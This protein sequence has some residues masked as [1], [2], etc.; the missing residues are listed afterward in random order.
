[1][2]TATAGKR[3][4]AL[5]C[6]AAVFLAVAAAC[7]KRPPRR[8]GGHIGGTLLRSYTGAQNMYRRTDWDGDG[9]LE[10]AFPFTRLN[11]EVTDGQPIRIIDDAFANASRDNSPAGTPVPRAGCV[12]VDLTGDA[13]AGPYDDGKGNFVNGC[14]LCGYPAEYGRSGCY[15]YIV[16]VRGTVYWKDT[17]GQPVTVFPDVGKEGWKTLAA[18]RQ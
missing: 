17:G 11:T 12:F 1:M 18:L 16:D 5:A 2:K 6:A 13:I 7:R 8:A 4:K 15:T 14:G 3:T 10:Y 9:I